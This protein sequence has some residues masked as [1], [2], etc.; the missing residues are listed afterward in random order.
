MRNRSYLLLGVLAASACRA[1]E[2]LV[3]VP[4]PPWLDTKVEEQGKLSAPEG[5]RVGDVLHGMASGR[6]EAEWFVLLDNAHCY[7]LSG[8]GG[9]GVDRLSLYLWDP[10]GRRAESQRGGGPSVLTKYCPS[11]AG[12]FKL[13]ARTAGGIGVVGIGIYAV[14]PDAAA[15]AAPAPAIEVAIAAPV[16]P[17]PDVAVPDA[18]VAEDPTI[19]LHEA[20]VGTPY[21]A[22]DFAAPS[23]PPDPVVEDRPAQPDPSNTWIGGYWWWSGGLGRYVWVSGV[24]RSPPP[25]ETWTQ[26]SWIN[27]GSNQFIWSPGVWTATGSPPLDASILTTAPPDAPDE[28]QG[29]PPDQESLWIP[30]FYLWSGGVY[31]WHAGSWGRPPSAGLMY[32]GARYAYVGGRYHYQPGRWDRPFERRG[33]VYRPD[34]NVRAGGHIRPVAVPEHLVAAH[35]GYVTA[36]ARVV[37]HG[38]VAR[39]G[40]PVHAVATHAAAATGRPGATSAVAAHSGAAAGRP[41]ASG[42]TSPGRVSPGPRV[43]PGPVAT[44][45]EPARVGAPPPRTE[46]A[47]VAAPAPRVEP[48]KVIAPAPKPPPPPPAPAPPPVRV[49]PPPPRPAPAP[50]A[51]PPKKKGER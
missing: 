16:A 39:A 45:A 40:A 18:I 37:A 51:A 20:V 41:V 26:G 33:T 14:A 7:W 49:A 35:G 6:T 29:D 11:R 9:D 25:D 31:G 28:A 34:I 27:N 32:V 17:E 2:V 5:Q 4:P 46:P 15:P 1:P 19:P 30:G 48:V 44:H 3:A 38:G 10:A 21:M 8:V 22:A 47:R 13:H 12:Q 50:A 36:S 24:W 43:G 42:P 23:A